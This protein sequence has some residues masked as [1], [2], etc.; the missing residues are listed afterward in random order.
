MLAIEM[1]SEP[2]VL[3]D[4]YV[5]ELAHIE[6]LGDGNYRLLCVTK[7]Q[8]VY[9]GEEHVITVKMVTTP[10]AMLRGARMV[11]KCLGVACWCAAKRRLH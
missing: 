10:A 4:V 6:D 5:S 2:V 9:G 3:E 8:S 7:H 11:L 1:L